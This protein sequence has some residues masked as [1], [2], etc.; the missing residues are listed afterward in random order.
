MNEYQKRII[1]LL[2]NKPAPKQTFQ[3][4]RKPKT[5]TN[6]QKYLAKVEKVLAAPEP[7]PKIVT[8]ESRVA[9]SGATLQAK[10]VSAPIHVDGFEFVLEQRQTVAR[11]KRC[12]LGFAG[13]DWNIVR[14]KMIGHQQTFHG[15]VKQA[16]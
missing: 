16:A 10:P 1:E 6:W 5:P 12:W 9:M 15:T 4:F 11:C 13:Y 2:R 14:P 3:P 8:S 7:A